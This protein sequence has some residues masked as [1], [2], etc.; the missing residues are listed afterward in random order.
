MARPS[1]PKKP[2]PAVQNARGVALRVLVEARKSGHDSSL[3][4]HR[5][6]AE[7]GFSGRDN[8]FA[9]LLVMQTLRHLHVTDAL[10]ANCLREPIVESKAP[11]ALMALRM[12]VVQ[13]LWLETSAHAAVNETVELVKASPNKAL[14]GLV[15]AVLKRVAQEG[16]AMLAAMDAEKASLPDWLWHSWCKSYGEEAT[17]ATARLV[18]QIPAVDISLKN[19]EEAEHWASA[20]N[21]VRL[22]NGSLRLPHG[23]GDIAQLPGFAEGAWWVQDAAASLPATLLAKDGLQGKQVLDLCAAPGGKTAQLAAQGAQVTA[24]DRSAKRLE[25]VSENLARLELRAELVEADIL[26]WEPKQRYDAILL[27]A[28]CSATGTLRRQPD[29]TLGK[30]A[31]DVAD[32]AVIQQR[33]LLRALEWLKPGGVLVYCVCSLEKAEGEAHIQP[34][35]DQRADVRLSPIAKAELPGLEEAVTMEGCLRTLP[36]FW[37]E[38]GGMDGFFAARI[39]KE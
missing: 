17:R 37:A 9:T 7:S 26:K 10:L 19:P 23:A 15:N 35:L 24:V 32:L 34:V 36:H 38:Q 11:Y 5:A 31:A 16:N 25:Q 30:T 29:V 20:L 18:S 27:D 12:G 6:L 14:A 4:L 21:A 28:I 2:A 39:I 8:G 1:T 3:L 22:P 33:M 13:L